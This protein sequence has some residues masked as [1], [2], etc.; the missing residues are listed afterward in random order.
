MHARKRQVGVDRSRSSV[1]HWISG[2]NE[3]LADFAPADG[4]YVIGEI[5][6]EALID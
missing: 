1:I 2:I 3:A 6:P 4:F 5:T